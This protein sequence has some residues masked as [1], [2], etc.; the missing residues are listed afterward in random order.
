M[1]SFVSLGARESGDEQ[2]VLV[3]VLRHATVDRKLFAAGS[4]VRAW[5]IYADKDKCGESIKRHREYRQ[6]SL[7]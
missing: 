5:T 1:I 4:R 3:F 2:D 6:I 7:G